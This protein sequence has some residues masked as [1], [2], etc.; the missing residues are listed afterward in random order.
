MR[1]LDAC[2]DVVAKIC[3]RSWKQIY[4][5]F[6]TCAYITVVFNHCQFLVLLL[7]PSFEIPRALTTVQFRKLYA[8]CH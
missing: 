5:F 2:F 3:Y 8:F 7:V 4:C 1:R 6:F